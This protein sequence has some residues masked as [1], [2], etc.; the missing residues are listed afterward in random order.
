MDSEKDDAF[1]GL[2]P[3]KMTRKASEQPEP[4]VGYGMQTAGAAD[5]NVLSAVVGAVVSTAQNIAGKFRKIEP[6]KLDPRLNS[7]TVT[8]GDGRNPAVL[9]MN[10]DGKRHDFILKKA[11][12]EQALKDGSLPLENLANRCLQIHDER[13]AKASAAYE[14]QAGYREESRYV[15]SMHL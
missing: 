11:S 3:F 13:T 2:L 4:K 6:E 8:P 12:T 14:M 7:V 15:T 1:E 5:S 10:I 9:S